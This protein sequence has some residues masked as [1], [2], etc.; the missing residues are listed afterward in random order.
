M[1]NFK[2]NYI[3][4][5]PLLICLV[6]INC[7]SSGEFNENEVSGLFASALKEF[8]ENDFYNA[9]VKFEKFTRLYP[10][11]SVIDSAQSYLAESYYGL[12]EYIS[13]ASEYQNLIR[14][15]P[16]SKLADKAQ[17]KIA[18][19]YYKLS[20]EYSLDQQ[21]TLKAIN[22]FIILMEDYPA[23][24]YVVEAEKY[25]TELRE[26]LAKKRFKNGEQYKKMG[27]HTAAKSCFLDVLEYWMDTKWA[28]MA[29]YNIG[30]SEMK[31]E[32]SDNAKKTFE[33]LL[34]IYPN[35]ELAEKAKLILQEIN[36]K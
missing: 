26:K 8:N 27:Y 34:R 16:N 35:H 11:N 28:P 17:Y 24:E 23:S 1:L 19:S 9:R 12:K 36:S 15:F 21:Y 20:P 2:S 18:L 10:G 4:C 6:L 13:A 33:E 5:I 31:L 32:D 29:M 3:K 30:E 14:Q 22:E 7:G 25:I